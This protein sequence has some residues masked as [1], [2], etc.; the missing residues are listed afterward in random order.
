MQYRYIVFG[1]L[2]FAAVT[3]GQVVADEDGERF[4]AGNLD[5]ETAAMLNVPPDDAVD[6]S[7]GS[8][9][10]DDMTV[11]ASGNVPDEGKDATVITGVDQDSG[12]MDHDGDAAS[13]DSVSDPPA[14]S[15]T[16]D[17]EQVVKENTL[18]AYIPEHDYS[19]DGRQRREMTHDLAVEYPTGEF[20]PRSIVNNAWG[21][22]EKLTFQITYGFYQAGTATM[23]VLDTLDINGSQCY[24]IKTT[25]HSN[26]F[27]SSF[28]KVRDSVES[29]IDVDGIFSRR[30]E[31]RLREGGYKS[32]QDCRFLS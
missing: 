22:G 5:S 30:F 1:F 13:P 32:R 10:G 8:A 19:K 4:R 11:L 29:F 9:V 17:D 2:L 3:A 15:G 31:K 12:D 6:K 21:V 23:S 14:L 7:T 18:L 25:A 27:I 16:T 20:I 24:H 28:Y 26:K